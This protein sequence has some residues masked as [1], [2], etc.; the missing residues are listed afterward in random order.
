MTATPAD[1][2]AQQAGKRNGVQMNAA[3]RTLRE[4]ADALLAMDLE[5][6]AWDDAVRAIHELMMARK[7]SA[8]CEEFLTEIVHKGWPGDWK[9]PQ[10]V[11]GVGQVKPY[12]TAART[13][14]QHDD[15]VTAVV[16]ANLQRAD[17]EI[18]DPFTVARWIREAAGFAR[19]KTGV[20]RSLGLH[21]DEFCQSKPGRRTLQIVSDDE[22]GGTT[23]KDG[24]P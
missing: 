24:A 18:P 16:D 4:K 20:L 15:L 6:I 21:I 12:R 22:I 14:W 2:A 5:G 17:G 11:E 13:E 9:T 1:V 10:V 19:W 3:A 7:A 23:H 8:A